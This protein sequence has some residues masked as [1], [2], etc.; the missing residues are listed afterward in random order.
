[1]KM[2]SDIPAARPQSNP[3]GPENGADAAS[4]PPPAFGPRQLRRAIWLIFILWTAAVVVSAVWNV[5]VMRAAMMDAAERDARDSFSRDMLYLTN[6][7]NMTRQMHEL[8][9]RE[10]GALGHITS[11]KPLRRENTPDAW[12]T[13][14]LRSF[15]KGRTEASSRQL[16]Q[17]RPYLRFMKPLVTEAVC[18]RCHAAQ[19]Y[20]EGDIRGGISV[21]VPLTPYLAL[22]QTRMW[23]IVGAH[24]GLWA[25][26]VLGIFVGGHQMG[27]R[28][29]RQVRAE[30]ETRHQANFL[31]YNPN[32]VLELSAAGEINC[33]NDATME[34]ARA[35]GRDNPAQILPPGT[36]ALV[37]E[38]LATG[39]PKLR[40]ETRLGARIISW[41]F[42]PV[43]FDNSVHG[44]AGD[45]TD[46]KQA[47]E[48][49]RHSETK[50]RT[51][52]DS[53]RDAVTLA[54]T[55]GFFDCNQA[56]LAMFG[57]ATREEFWAKHP[58]DLSPLVQPDGTDS[59]TSANRRIAAALEKGGD[60]FEWMHKRANGEIFPA[61]V[62]LSAMELDGRP[63]LQGVIRDITERKRMEEKLRQLSRAV[64]QS[65]VSIIITN[66]AGDIEYVNP[67]FVEVTGYPMA[68]VLGRNPRIL[69]SGDKNPESYRELWQTITAGKEW[70]GEFHNRKKNGE[71]YWELASISPIRDPAGRVTHYV[72]VKEDIT[73]RKRTEAERDRLIFDLQKALANVKLLSGLL[74]ICANCKKIRDDKGYWSQVENY[75]QQHS[76][77][78][79]T[80]GICPECMKKLYPDLVK[81]GI[82]SSTR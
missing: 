43:K 47:E 74:P 29:D 55:N 63:V 4:F 65:P 6:S 3:T 25:L 11:L 45:I 38:C 70:S 73:D 12:E 41:S 78:T 76:E 15:E 28:L 7:A 23:Y 46:R 34:M 77:A 22:A 37:H 8:K 64:E 75:I 79:F 52:Y 56:A 54:D 16:Y 5:R 31:R 62:L 57:F 69:K 26:A 17:G 9:A 24:A 1:M 21:A 58:A 81:N 14:V 71:L 36:A 48:A 44:Y 49:L 80:H 19:G 72:A 33:F 10:D 27:Q 61:E 53:T 35:L 20:H 60:H 18:L 32:P 42:F 2:P 13:A 82:G 50:F 66:T 59:L 30:W 51:L 68:E 39:K 67:K 40:V